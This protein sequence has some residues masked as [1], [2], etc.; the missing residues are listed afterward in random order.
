MREVDHCHTRAAAYDEHQLISIAYDES[1]AAGL[2]AT[3]SG[4]PPHDPARQV[5]MRQP[6]AV[7]GTVTDVSDAVHAI[8]SDILT[9]AAPL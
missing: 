3:A 7:R 5:E 4:R 1:V 8:A 6:P 2:E 9:V